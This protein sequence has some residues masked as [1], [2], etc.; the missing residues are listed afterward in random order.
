M[1]NGFGVLRNFNDSYIYIGEWKDS[2]RDGVARSFKKK[3]ECFAKYKNN[4]KLISYENCG[5]LMKSIC[6]SH[7]YLEDF[8]CYKKY[9]E[10]NKFTR[11]SRI[12]ED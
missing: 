4:A 3:K 5:E 2:Q 10:I 7:K 1:Y 6:E 12:M 11:M 9:D 8:F